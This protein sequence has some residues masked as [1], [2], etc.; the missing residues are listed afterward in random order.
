[1]LT[2]A[3]VVCMTYRDNFGNNLVTNYVKQ[4]FLLGVQN[5]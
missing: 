1:M 4:Q 3:L 2:T 5:E